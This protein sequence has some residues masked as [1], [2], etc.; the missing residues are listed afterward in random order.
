MSQVRALTKTLVPCQEAYNYCITPYRSRS[1][2]DSE[3]STPSK[4]DNSKSLG[5]FCRRNR[6]LCHKHS[7]WSWNHWV[8]DLPSRICSNSETAQL[9]KAKNVYS[10]LKIFLPYR[11]LKSLNQW[12]DLSNPNKQTLSEG[13]SRGSS[14]RQNHLCEGNAGH[15][16]PW[17]RI[18]PTRFY[19]Q[20]MY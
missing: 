4:K 3:T 19:K 14:N 6:Q 9:K 17:M 13:P 20:G 2:P 1:R 10:I 7:A 5:N 16:D 11:L 12:S 18:S 15:F 8:V